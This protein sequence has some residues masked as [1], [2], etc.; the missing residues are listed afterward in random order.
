MDNWKQEFYEEER[1]W[2][3]EKG[4]EIRIKQKL[5]G[6]SRA[7]FALFYFCHFFPFFL[8]KIK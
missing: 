5:D 6:L 2:K 3:E 1:T 4:A 8:K 7:A